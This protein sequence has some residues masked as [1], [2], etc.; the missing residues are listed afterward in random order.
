MA[1]VIGTSSPRLRRPEATAIPR[2]CR[3]YGRA[4]RN[5]C[6]DRRMK[7]V[8]V[9]I[10]LGTIAHAN[11]LRTDPIELTIAPAAARWKPNVSVAV[12]LKATNIT[13]VKRSMKVMSCSW[14]EH[15]RS[16]DAALVSESWSCNENGLV[17]VE[18]EPGASKTWTLKMVAAADA[19]R[20]PHK[21]R[22]IFTPRDGDAMWSNLVTINVT[23]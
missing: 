14:W 5:T 11:P 2:A 7:V 8:L 17:T 4:R 3:C 6:H 20:G 19:K 13:R 18:L 16:S 1:V 12:V 23:K 9:V 10:A 22:L 15:V 21:F